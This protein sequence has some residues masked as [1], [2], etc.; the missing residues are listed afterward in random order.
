VSIDDFVLSV[1]WF[2]DTDIVSMTM[3]RGLKAFIQS[4]FPSLL[5][6]SLTKM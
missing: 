1:I 3:E 4:E 2:E 5:S 6:L